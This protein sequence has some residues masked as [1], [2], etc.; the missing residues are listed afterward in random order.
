VRDN[1]ITEKY[2][3]LKTQ[4][5]RLSY[6]RALAIQSL[7][8]EAARVFNENEESILNGSFTHSL[9]DK[10]KYKAQ[11]N[12]IIA[13]SVD[14]MYRSKEVIEKEI[15]GYRVITTLLDVFTTA[16]NNKYDAKE[17]GFDKLIL[18]LIPEEYQLLQDDLYKRLLGVCSFISGMSDRYAIL[19]F[20]KV[21]A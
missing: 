16:V 15:K 19:L 8:Y 6:L 5:E 17:T 11:L 7:I 3:A 9:L 20:D 14:K 2:A 18:A 12:D 10:C 13:I 21:K 1:L 4:K